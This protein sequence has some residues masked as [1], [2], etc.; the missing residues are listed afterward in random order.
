MLRDLRFSDLYLE[1]DGVWFKRSAAERERR[2][3]DGPWIDVI[4]ELRRHLQGHRT[5]LDF[6]TEWDGVGLRVQR[7]DTLDGDVYVCRRLLQE[8]IEF[9][10]LGFQPELV[11]AL[12]SDRFGSGGL[13]LW[14]G[15]TGEGKSMS[16]A[17]WILKRLT[18]YGGT[19]C[20]VENPV[21]I[22]MQGRHGV[23]STV[24][25]CYQTE[26]RSDDEYGPAILRLMRAN[27]SMIMLGE[28]L[29]RSAAAQAALAGSSGH[30]VSATLHA[31]DVPTALE[32]MKNMVREAGLDMGLLADSL[33]A[34]IHQSMRIMEFQGGERYVITA[35]PLIVSGVVNET[36]IRT[37][38]RKGD[39]SLLSSELER[40]R[41][42]LNTA[43]AN[44]RRL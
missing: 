8:P 3:L 29:T 25:T 42:L 31:K 18:M 37:N 26:I 33:C 7:L 28:I 19:A 15:A 43:P 24:G 44:S 16:Q 40:Q 4:N 20:T 11:K 39:F 32:R 1:P 38:L 21:E 10:S 17:S 36:A 2:V 34:V 30:L 13:V 5:G 22:R 12:L 14:T 27:P 23:G 6:R 9:E 35:S 41:T